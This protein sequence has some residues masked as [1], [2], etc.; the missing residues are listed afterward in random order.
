MDDNEIAY[1]LMKEHIRANKSFKD[2][3]GWIRHAGTFSEKLGIPYKD[4]LRFGQRIMT[5]VFG[6]EMAA[7]SRYPYMKEEG[8]VGA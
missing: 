3:R 7:L 4:L 8:K 6:E 2:I 5:E 1:L